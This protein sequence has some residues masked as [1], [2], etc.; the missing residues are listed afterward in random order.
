[1]ILR[2]RL[3]AYYSWQTREMCVSAR[4]HDS[5]IRLASR[6]HFRTEIEFIF[7]MSPV[8]AWETFDFPGCW[9]PDETTQKSL[10]ARNDA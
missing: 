5:M 10:E 1:M 8:V 7:I 9:L 2:S 6:T 3:A 4:N